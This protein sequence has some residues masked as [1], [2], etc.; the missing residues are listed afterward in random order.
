MTVEVLVQLISQVSDVSVQ[1][2]NLHASSRLSGQSSRLHYHL[3][4]T[5]NKR[6]KPAT[7]ARRLVP[8][9]MRCPGG[10]RGRPELPRLLPQSHPCRELRWRTRWAAPAAVLR[11][12]RCS[13]CTPLPDTPPCRPAAPKPCPQPKRAVRDTCSTQA[14]GSCKE[15]LLK[16]CAQD[17]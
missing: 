17:P 2:E 3:I 1:T 7:P 4:S 11:W 9:V 13:R 15:V 12:R 16:L 10:W 8:C 5:P 6:H 14:A